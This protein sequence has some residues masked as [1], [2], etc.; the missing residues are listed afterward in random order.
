V[1][2]NR[3]PEFTT[4]DDPTTNNNAALAIAVLASW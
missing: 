3:K 1:R 2:I 4:N